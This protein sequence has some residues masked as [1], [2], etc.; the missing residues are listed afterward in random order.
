MNHCM[1]VSMHDYDSNNTWTKYGN[2][3]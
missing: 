3:H 1:T 2:V